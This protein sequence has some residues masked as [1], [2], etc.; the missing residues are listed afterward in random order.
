MIKDESD[1]VVPF[2]VAVGD[3]ELLI[4]NF[5]TRGQLFEAVLTA[6]V[7]CEGTFI[8]QQNSSSS[9]GIPNGT[10]LPSKQ[11]EK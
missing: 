1:E 5:T 9:P 3:T 6:Q 11:E 8:P 7:A 2:G 10:D 4:S